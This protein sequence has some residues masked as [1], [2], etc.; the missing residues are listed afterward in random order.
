MTEIRFYTLVTVG[1][2]TF[3]VAVI[4]IALVFAPGDI[5]DDF[6]SGAI[7][8][9]AV[10]VPPSSNLGG[11][12]DLIEQEIVSLGAF[13]ESVG[14]GAVPAEASTLPEYELRQLRAG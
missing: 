7:Q 11:R 2:A 9:S 14:S 10:L 12:S 4:I 8:P 13:I 5:S 6:P 3:I 1:W